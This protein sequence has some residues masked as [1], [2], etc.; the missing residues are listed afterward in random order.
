MIIKYKNSIRPVTDEDQRE[1]AN[2]IHFE[3][4]VHRHLD[5]CPPLDWIGRHPFLVAEEDGNIIATLACPPDPPSVAWIRLFAADAKVS[6]K[7]VWEALWSEA[8]AQL[9]DCEGLVWAAAIPLQPWFKTLL[10]ESGFEE[11]QRVVL[12]DWLHGNIP[13]EK[14]HP[15]VLIKPMLLGNLKAVGQ[16]DEVS[17]APLWRNSLNA[18]EYAFSQAV[19][20][21]I[22]VLDKQV[23]GYQISTATPMG[24]HLARL[25]VH[26]EHQG[27]GIGYAL[28]RDLLQQFKGRDG[29]R[30]TVNTQHDNLASLALYR[31]AGF[32]STSEIYPVYQYPFSSSDAG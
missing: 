27:R 24:G 29:E 9:M 20:A 5:W 21:T 14:P 10:E 13:P 17:F 7:R 23:V 18:L 16:I 28:L 25:A 2:L 15:D 1:L 6:R 31:K 4:H 11:T 12:M 30:V 3:M 19:V 8:S 32:R 22:V 26:P